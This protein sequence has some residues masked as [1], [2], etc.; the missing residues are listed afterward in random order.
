M[1]ARKPTLSVVIPIL[2][3]ERTIGSI[4][5][6]IR[7]WG[8]A[9]EIIVVDDGSKDNS[10]AALRHFRS[11]IRVIT[12]GANR[13][14]GYA[15]YRGVVES[16]G[17]MIMFFDGDVVGLT[18]KDLDAMLR[19]MMQNRADMTLGVARFWG[20]GS[21]E[22]FN[23]ITGQ[24]IIW[25]KN[26]VSIAEKMKTVGYGVELY[27]NELHKNKRVV[28]VRLPHVFILG[29]LEKQNIPDAMLSYIGEARELIAQFV[30]GQAKDITPQTKKVLRTLQSYLVSALEFFK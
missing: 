27:L 20:A 14:K 26:I 28:S 15:M 25:R 11:H 29:K 3:E 24:R 19:P 7:T 16:S 13:G 5:E 10:L 1:N 2:N 22:P 4:V 12:Y 30:V 9:N 18:H 8:K 21:F 6:V 17:D 23:D